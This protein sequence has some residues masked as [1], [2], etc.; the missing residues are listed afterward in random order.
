MSAESYQHAHHQGL[1]ATPVLGFLMLPIPCELH[2]KV[3]WEP[4]SSLGETLCV[5]Q[6]PQAGVSPEQPGPGPPCPPRSISLHVFDFETRCATSLRPLLLHRPFCNAFCCISA[7]LLALRDSITS[8]PSCCAVLSI[9]PE[10]A[11]SCRPPR[12]AVFRISLIRA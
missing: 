1:T 7:W 3:S 9:I 2:P 8:I 4:L 11:C 10:L 12:D 5:N 6:G